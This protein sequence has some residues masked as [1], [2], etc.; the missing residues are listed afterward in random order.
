MAKKILKW[1][2]LGLLALLLLIQVVPYGRDHTNPPVVAEPQW[3]SPRTRELASRACFDCHSNETKWPWYAS[4]APMSW[5]VQSHVDE[6]RGE[7]NFSRFDQEQRHAGGAAHELE[8]G[9]MP[10]SGY[11][12]LHPEAD[13]TEQEK[14]ELL[15]GLRAT[16]PRKAGK[17]GEGK[18]D[19]H[20]GDDDHD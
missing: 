10:L 17:H 6:G 12:L 13:L 2:S 4:V 11:V 3:D 20:E 7:L 1:G 18:R 16:F 14:A 19:K 9:E 8:E 15:A 5:L